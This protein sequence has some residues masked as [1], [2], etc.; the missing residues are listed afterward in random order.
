MTNG[1]GHKAISNLL[2]L[3]NQSTPLTTSSN[4]EPQGA[5]HEKKNVNL[6]VVIM[7]A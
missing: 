6:I 4:S 5:F 1:I 3:I 7:S 2:L